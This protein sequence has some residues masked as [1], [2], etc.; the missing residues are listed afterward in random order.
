MIKIQ[1]LKKNL[2]K[3]NSSILDVIKSLNNSNEKICLILDHKKKICGLITDG[4]LRRIILK[5]KNFKTKITKLYKKKFIFL[6]NDNSLSYAKN[7]FEKKKD[8]EYI[9]VLK[10]DNTLKGLFSRKDLIQKDNYENEVFILAGGLGKRLHTLTDFFPKPMISVGTRPL[11]ESILYSLKSSGFKNISISVNYL[12]EKIKD[13]FGNGENLKLRINYFSE[14]KRLGTAGPLFFLKKKNLKKTIIVLNG[15]I[16]TNLK[17]ENLLNF[18]QKEKNDFTICCHLYTSKIPYGVLEL[19]NRNKNLIN[20][21]PEIK[22][23]VNSGIYCIEP[24]LLKFLKNN[25]YKD[26]SDFINYLKRKKKKIGFFKIHEN[27][28]DIGDYN[29][30]MEARESRW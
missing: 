19:N 8:I 2:V 26:M 25:E 12:Q 10:K 11:L 24:K 13:Y 20:E 16:Y 30:L 3:K 15:D 28:Y 5:E 18:H 7:I 4:D 6:K 23:L 17:K 9:P 14:K 22:Y 1:S 21:K 27:L 29:K